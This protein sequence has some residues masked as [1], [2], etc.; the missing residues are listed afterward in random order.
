MTGCF[1][2]S[3]LPFGKRN[4]PYSCIYRTS[5]R[6]LYR[7]TLFLGAL[8]LGKEAQI[9]QFL[10]SKT[11]PKSIAS[12]LL[13][14]TGVQKLFYFLV[15]HLHLI[16]DNIAVGSFWIPTIYTEAFHLQTSCTCAAPP[17]WVPH[18]CI[19]HHGS[20]KVLITFNPNFIHIILKRLCQRSFS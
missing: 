16:A 8:N 14:N 19:F 4:S 18:F 11:R 3:R 10:M 17:F 9:R 6:P 20:H 12:P 13:S 15:T 2:A 1:P 5:P 7:P